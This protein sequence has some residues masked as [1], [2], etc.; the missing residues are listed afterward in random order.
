M[1]AAVWL[2]GAGGHLA[3]LGPPTHAP[4]KALQVRAQGPPS[5]PG[6]VWDGG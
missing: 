4:P 3:L 1:F 6:T 2:S 5:L